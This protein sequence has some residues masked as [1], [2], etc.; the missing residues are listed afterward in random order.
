MNKRRRKHISKEINIRRS[1]AI[2]KKNYNNVI[3]VVIMMILAII[4][5]KLGLEKKE[6]EELVYQYK[7]E[8]KSDYEVLLKENDFYSTMILPADLYYASKSI[9]SFIINFEYSFKGNNKIDI[10]YDYSITA[11][12]VGMVKDEYQDKEV[13]NKSFSIINNKSNEQINI[14]SFS[15]KE[16]IDIDYKKYND[17][18]SS[19][20]NEYGIKLDAVLKVRF[21]ISYQTN[22]INY[23]VNNEKIDDCIELNIPITN[24]VTEVKENYENENVINIMQPIDKVN[25]YIYYVIAGLFIISALIIYIVKINK[26]KMTPQEKYEKKVNRILKYYRD[27]IVTVNDEPNLN[28]LK[29]MELITLDDLIDVAEQNNCNI[30]RY[31]D[32]TNRTNYLYAIVGEYAYYYKII[33]S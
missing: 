19:Y 28:D 31:E 15:I 30:I 12:L 32:V 3:I 20:E 11:E 23:S 4:F 17:L 1:R 18:V 24:T 16:K 33:I 14:D 29:M 13:W 2:N 25:E 7:V 5:I 9:D 6:N 21:N 27:I 22:F 10:K 8:R 26:N